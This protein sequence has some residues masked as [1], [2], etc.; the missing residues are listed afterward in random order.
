[1]R[2]LLIRHLWGVAGAWEDVFPRI[3]ELGYHGIEAALPPA[4]DRKRFR[5]LLDR[6]GFEFIAQIFTAGNDVNGHL[7]S[8]RRQIA[9][10]PHQQP[11]RPRRLG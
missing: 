5:E 2:L 4:A 6:H 10:T 9:S 1:M 11:Q 8:F 7:E 3:K